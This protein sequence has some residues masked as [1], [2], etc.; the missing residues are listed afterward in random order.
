MAAFHTKNTCCG[1]SGARRHVRASEASLF[2][3]ALLFLLP[4]CPFCILVYS[5]AVS[6]C[7]GAIWHDHAPRWTSAL[8]VILA[9]LAA[10]LILAGRRR[11]ST[12][13]AF[14]LALAGA[15]L[16]AHSELA[17][18]LIE[19][20]RWGAAL[21][22]AAALIQGATAQ[23]ARRRGQPTPNIRWKRHERPFPF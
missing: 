23:V 16:I 20:Y 5:S 6:L 13:A 11:R 17:S 19:P 22:L 1:A 9:F 15:L 7:G 21:V 14:S 3:A 18:G 12:W 8:S 2:G 4:H 10:G